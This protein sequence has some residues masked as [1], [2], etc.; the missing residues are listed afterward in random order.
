MA[1][2]DRTVT[3]LL[4]AFAAADPT[5]GGGSAS[6][7]AGAVS[8]S[9]LS[10]VASMPK[11]KTNAVAEREI[12]DE[13]NTEIVQV[14]ETLTA[15]IDRDAD[16]YDL[17]VAAFRKPKAT[18]EEKAAR[19]AAIQDAMRVATEIPLETMK[20]CAALLRLQR[21][22]AEHGN[23]NAASDVHVAAL[24]A[25]AAMQGARS[26]VD[27]NLPGI[28]NADIAATLRQQADEYDRA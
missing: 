10:M 27:I 3:G 15:L 17:V 7:L 20:A 22:V 12:L 16:A 13:A 23:T 14:R 6:A 21:I 8:A 19:K 5:P 11:S 2:I 1:L 18:D 26:N 4:D 9:L 25:R 24:L 28:T